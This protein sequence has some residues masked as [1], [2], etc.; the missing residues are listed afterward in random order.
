[1][2]GLRRYRNSCVGTHIWSRQ[3]HPHTGHTFPDPLLKITLCSI[4]PSCKCS[5]SPGKQQDGGEE[6]EQVWGSA[7]FLPKWQNGARLADGA[8]T[9]PPPHIFSHTDC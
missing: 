1:M 3:G 5:L 2:Q 8:H 6:E 9:T 4:K 7:I